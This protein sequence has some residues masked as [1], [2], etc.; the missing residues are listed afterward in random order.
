MSYNSHYRWWL[1]CK[2][3]ST[4]FSPAGHSGWRKPAGLMLE[5]SNTPVRRRTH[6]STPRSKTL[7]I[8][9]GR[10][11]S[12]LQPSLHWG[13]KEKGRC[14]GALWSQ[15]WKSTAFTLK[16]A[17]QGN[18]SRLLPNGPEVLFCQMDI[19][20]DYSSW[21]LCSKPVFWV[22]KMLR[23]YYRAQKIGVDILR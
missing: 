1:N 11:W 14:R 16:E 3:G 21:W 15:G 4:W 19:P 10:W 9:L 17:K 12:L 6:C 18:D 2:S 8:P 13:Q 20:M 5:C 22:P 23:K 7:T